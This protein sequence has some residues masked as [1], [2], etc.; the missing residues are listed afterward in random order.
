MITEI[1]NKAKL[2][3]ERNGYPKP[4]DEIWKYTDIKNFS[5]C[6]DTP[7]KKDNLNLD[8]VS[9]IDGCINIILYNGFQY[10][11]LESHPGLEV[12]SY[13]EILT[14]SDIGDHFLKISRVDNSS[15]VAH[16]TSSFNDVLHI[17]IKSDL[18]TPINIINISD[19]LKDNEIIFPRIYIHAKED[20][21]STVFIKNI[22]INS[23]CAINSV[24]EIYLE[25]NSSLEII[26]ITDLKSQ[27]VIESIYFHQ[28]KNSKVKFLSS[29]FGGK[30]YRSNINIDINGSN[31]ENISGVLILGRDKDHI[32][33]HTNINHISQ[34]SRS[35]FTCRSLLKDNSKGIFNGKIF[36]SNDAFGSDA[37]LNNNNLLLSK[38][39]QIQSNPQLEIN[40]ED[41]KC[42]HGSTSGNL[43]KE[44]L[45]YLRSRGIEEV[46][47]NQILINGFVSKLLEQFSCDDLKLK[48]SI[49]EWIQK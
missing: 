17:T 22:G 14:S 6:I 33:Y 20:T 43:D 13:D 47:A 19:G 49:K 45:F 36:V 29:A 18:D 35:D 23:K 37:T 31:C 28:K 46:N 1:R 12:K 42:S 34:K 7:T 24:T 39:A 5:N 48:E 41:V 3:F 38:K 25:N 21:N 30:L 8:H 15:V 10:S 9:T 44:A 27:E 16:N 40:C 26:H 4:K 32:D 11:I 2:F